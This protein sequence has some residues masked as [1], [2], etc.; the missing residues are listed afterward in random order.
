MC[1]CTND[2]PTLILSNGNSI[3]DEHVSDGWEKSR[4]WSQYGQ[5]HHGICLV[6]SK[7]ELEA[8]LAEK[9]SEI[10]FYRASPVQYSQQKLRW[11]EI[12]GTRLKEE[13][14][15]EYSLNFI[16]ENS[17]ELFF[18]KHVDYRDEAEFRVVVLDPDK[19]LEYLDI[20]SFIKCVI[21][22]DRTPEAYYPSIEQMCKHLNVEITR[23]RWSRSGRY[24]YLR[25]CRTSNSS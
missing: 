5:N 11:P 16:K 9:E 21:V 18:I 12:D 7:R 20:A 6:F 19:N 14:V 10:K 23:A 3:K 15:E 4:M 22:A 2:K 1:F 24:M 17:K 25:N 8:V 13:G